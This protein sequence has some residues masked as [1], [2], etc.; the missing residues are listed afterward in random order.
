MPRSL[1]QP[2]FQQSKEDFRRIV[3]L[4]PPLTINL[5]RYLAEIVPEVSGRCFF[6]AEEV[7]IGL[8]PLTSK[9]GDSAC[10]IL[11]C[12]SPLVLRLNE[13]GCY[14]VIG[15][16]YIDGFMDGRALLGPLPT[17]SKSAKSYH[18]E[19][20]CNPAFVN[21]EIGRV[22]IEDPSLSPLPGEWR[23]ASHDAQSAWNWHVN[24]DTKEGY[25]IVED[26]RIRPE[27]LKCRGVKLKEFRLR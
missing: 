13:D 24:D 26:P 21:H 4:A 27:A 15:E 11:G 7:Y 16:C 25:D 2:D 20:S 18:E 23:V 9:L 3:E 17:Y 1:L 14:E 12:K 19:F 22:K 6:V 10:A 5:R 8:A